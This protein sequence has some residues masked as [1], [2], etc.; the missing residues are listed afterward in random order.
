MSFLC[1]FGTKSM[2]PEK[3]VSGHS[4]KKHLRKRKEI[5]SS[6]SVQ[7]WRLSA[8]P[9]WGK[10]RGLWGLARFGCSKLACKI[11]REK[12]SIGSVDFALPPGLEKKPG[13]VWNDSGTKS[14]AFSLR[15]FIKLITNPTKP[16]EIRRDIPSFSYL[17]MW[18]FV[19][20]TTLFLIFK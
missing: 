8:E 1:R 19:I 5:Q 16:Q 2:S 13:L 12:F 11:L 3:F 10:L 7:P 9:L 15:S 18:I 20:C 17:T 4:E 6:R 14:F